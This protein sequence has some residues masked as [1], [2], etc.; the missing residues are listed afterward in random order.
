VKIPQKPP[1]LTE[2]LTEL[3]REE[4]NKFAE[5]V[6]SRVDRKPEGKYVHWDELRHLPLPTGFTHRQWWL[7]IKMSRRAT[8]RLPFADS[9]QIGFTYSVSDNLFRLVHEIDRDA[10]GRIEVAELVTGS[11]TRD[12]HLVNSLIEESITS[13][14]LEGAATT[15]KVAKQ[16]LRQGRQPR[17]HGE[18]MIYNNYAAMQF[19]RKHK[20]LP[21]TP[22]LILQLQSTITDSTLEDP[23]A[24]GRWRRSEENVRVVDER[25]H[26]IL[27]VPPPAENIDERITE[28]CSFA[29]GSN[30]NSFIHPLIKAIAIHFMMGWIHPFVDGNGR[31]ARAL[32]YWSM[33]KSS[34]WLIE[35]TSISR[36]I[37]KTPA[38]YARAYLYTETDDNDLTYFIEHQL[39]VISAAIKSLLTYLAHKTKEIADTRQLIAS[40]PKLKG[41]LN[42]RQLAAMDHLLKHP[43]AAYRIQ[44]HRNANQVTYE[45]ARTDLLDLVGLGLLEK[46]RE[47]KSFVFEMSTK[48]REKLAG[49]ALSAGHERQP[50]QS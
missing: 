25:N 40:T 38:Q 45:T 21:L 9:K 31:T 50:W 44:E 26:E 6:G 27:Y 30:E 32:F 11:P 4:P 35:F 34:Y 28:L 36:V 48:L 18:Q 5:L 23:T 42:H 15:H 20:H 10:S 8:H 16:M 41:K 29:N 46:H 7:A 17:N 19:I 47:G 39:N 14:Q 13:S 2:L 22:A 37:K 3:A 12:R 43:Q 24:A 33:A 49:K 1:Q